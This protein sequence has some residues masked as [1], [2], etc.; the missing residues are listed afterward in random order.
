MKNFNQGMYQNKHIA[1][2]LIS[3]IHAVIDMR[4]TLTWL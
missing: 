3:I 2:R 4:F 1:R